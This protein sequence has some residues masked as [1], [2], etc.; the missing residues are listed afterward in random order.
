MKERRQLTVIT[1][2]Q[3]ELLTDPQDVG[4]ELARFWGRIMA[5]NGVSKTE[6]DS[7]LSGR[8]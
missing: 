7:Y 1:S 3:G 5:P 8:P 6:R 4:H 2:A